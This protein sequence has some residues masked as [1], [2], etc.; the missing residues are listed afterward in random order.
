M[1]EQLPTVFP[2][3]RDLQEQ[4]EYFYGHDT[5]AM[6]SLIIDASD[7]RDAHTAFNYAH[8]LL[9]K[10][11]EAK[12]DSVLYVLTAKAQCEADMYEGREDTLALRQ[13][14]AEM[15]YKLL[16]AS[17][18]QG[19]LEKGHD[20]VLGYYREVQV[21]LGVIP[22]EET[23]RRLTESYE[24]ISTLARQTPELADP[25]VARRYEAILKRDAKLGVLRRVGQVIMR[26][27]RQIQP[28]VNTTV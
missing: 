2:E 9:S 11:P 12:P 24:T 22:I 4:Y 13:V 15:L 8:S 5:A 19:F 25:V 3:D 20:F 14:K 23:K 21:F 10:G 6:M 26:S 18:A 16:E 1:R 28:P 27:L 7:E 17:L